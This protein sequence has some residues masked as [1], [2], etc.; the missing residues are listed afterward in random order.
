[1]SC[2]L[3]QWQR[4][5]AGSIISRL[6]TLALPSPFQASVVDWLSNVLMSRERIV[7]WQAWPYWSN[8]SYR[9]WQQRPKKGDTKHFI[10]RLG[11][12]QKWC[13]KPPLVWAVFHWDGDSNHQNGGK[14]LS[15]EQNKKKANWMIRLGDKG[16]FIRIIYKIGWFPTSETSFKLH[17]FLHFRRV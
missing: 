8:R 12:R 14:R 13:V 3:V 2:N 15:L 4:N 1:M 16:V 6:S 10:I 11:C 9:N 17:R 7:D 5:I